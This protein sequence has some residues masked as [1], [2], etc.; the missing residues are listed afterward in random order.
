MRDIYLLHIHKK[1][2]R[3][4]KKRGKIYVERKYYYSLFQRWDPKGGGNRDWEKEKGWEEGQRKVQYC[5]RNIGK[6]TLFK[7]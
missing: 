1:E 6:I 2:S 7:G 4:G 5:S 3:V